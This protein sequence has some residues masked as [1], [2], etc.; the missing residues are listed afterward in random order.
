MRPSK[1]EEDFARLAA[2]ARLDPGNARIWLEMA[3]LR[4]MASERHRALGML[5]TALEC[6]LSGEEFA[7]AWR[8]IQDLPH[9]AADEEGSTRTAPQSPEGAGAERAREEADCKD[10]ASRRD[11]LLKDSKTF[12]MLPWTAMIIHQDG[13]ALPCCQA[14]STE[15]TGNVKRESL[16]DIWNGSDMRQL[17][18]NMLAGRKSPHCQAC[19]ELEDADVHSMRLEHNKGLAGHFDVVRATKPDGSVEPF[20]LL[21][22]ELNLSNECNFACRYCHSERSTRWYGD[23]RRLWGDPG[24]P[25]LLA[26]RDDLDGLLREFEPLFPHLRRIHF[27]GGEPLIMRWHYA[28]LRRLIERRCFGVHLTYSTN[29]SGTRLGGEDVFGLWNRF[30]KV[31]VTASLDASGRRGEYIR[32]GQKWDQVVADRENLQKACPHVDFAISPTLTVLNSFALPDFH[33]EWLEK[34]YIRPPGDCNVGFLVGPAEY[35]IQ[36][37]PPRLKATVAEKY[38]RHIEYMRA[39]FGELAERDI[40]SFR[41][42]ANY[43]MK[44]DLSALIPRFREVT[45]SLDALR[46]ERFWDVFPELAEMAAQDTRPDRSAAASHAG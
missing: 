7:R 23:Y 13:R 36:I 39:E 46:G 32:H 29:F 9:D 31:T 18:R 30:G 15:E 24:H 44:R 34:R 38:E 45:E 37:L 5:Q 22:L 1:R 25:R 14:R 17:R 27:A 28:L 42:A 6:G 19:Y 20:R 21:T 41:S 33:R 26:A 10:I 2:E 11:E 4:A 40:R 12:C 43:M 35:R 3:K 16:L 8:E